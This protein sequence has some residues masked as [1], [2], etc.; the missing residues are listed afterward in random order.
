MPPTLNIVP[1]ERKSDLPPLPS[2]LIQLE[3]AVM[4]CD[5][6]LESLRLFQPTPFQKTRKL[7]GIW[8]VHTTNPLVALAVKYFDLARQ[9][10][11]EAFRRIQ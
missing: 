3:A 11:P 8:A 6:E 2:A 1:L 5:V 9:Y 7:Y 4:T 10:N